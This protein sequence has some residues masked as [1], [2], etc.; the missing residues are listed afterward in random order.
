VSLEVSAATDQSNIAVTE[1]SRAV[2]ELAGGVI[3]QA[4]HLRR[5]TAFIEE[6]ATTI[7]RIVADVEEQQSAISQTYQSR[8]TMQNEIDAITTLASELKSSAT[9]A[10]RDAATGNDAMGKTMSAMEAV[11]RE[12]SGAVDAISTLTA[13][14]QAIEEIISIIGEIADQTN[15]LALNAAIE[16]ARAGEH[17]RGFAVVATEVRKL[18][19]RSVSATR[20]IDGI[21]SS[22]R[23]EVLR[24]QRAMEL[25]AKATNEGLSLANASFEALETLGR[26][27]TQTDDVAVNVANR[28]GS[29][30]DV[31][32]HFTESEQGILSVTT[33]NAEAAADIRRA[34]TRISEA[35][36]EIT[37]M[38]EE[39]SVTAEQVSAAAAELAAQIQQLNGTAKLLHTEGETMTKLVRSFHIDER[40]ALEA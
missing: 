6:I 16:A 30:R 37:A 27:I 14:S 9:L 12:S 17:G 29:M 36:G 25:S 28:A 23:S 32:A 3:Q 10:R 15:L 20:E 13:R 21:L 4:S 38:A 24:A 18:A 22:I 8:V 11:R 31:S 1:I 35:L 7:N 33:R 26:A 39:Q 2:E 5:T 40:P 34:T 19:E